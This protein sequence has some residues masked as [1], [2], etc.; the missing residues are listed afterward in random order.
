[1]NN[2]V[3]DRKVD[4]LSIC[5]NREVESKNESTWFEYVYLVHQA[6]PEIDFKSVDT[7]VEFL[8]KKL[9]APLLID[10][11]TGGP[12][13]SREVNS[14]LASVAR[15]LNIGMGVGSQRAALINPELAKS[16][17]VVR[18]IAPEI[19][20]MA[21]IGGPQLSRGFNIDDAKRIIEMVKADAL[22]VHLNPLQ[23]LVQI[24][25][26]PYYKGVFSALEKLVS[27][28]DVPI[29]VKEVGC[30]ISREVAL[31]LEMIGVKAINVAG[32]GGTSWA[33]VEAI[34]AEEMGD[35]YKAR[36]GRT[37]WDWG[38]P[39]A[40]SI[41]E[42][43]SVTKLPIIA[44]GGI[45]SGIDIAKA[46]ALGADLAAIALP[47][48]RKAIK[49]GKDETFS[50][51]RGIIDEL[52]AAMFLT[53]ALNINEMKRKRYILVGKLKDWADSLGR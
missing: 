32:L 44:S 28:L 51:L 37:F 26:E 9:S 17:S 6:L 41:L 20:V 21:N 52:K 18:E 50:Y 48:I 39:T 24:E 10:C 19:F 4:H 34:R 46:I 22:A 30:G 40:A 15:D 43:R 1:L 25:G 27:E 3:Q 53:G 42:V 45:R 35:K 12:K 14:I 36:L 5:L 29:I 8:G 49:F 13:F 47:V 31:K 7:S 38:I 23:E 11:M 16:F 2:N 33:G